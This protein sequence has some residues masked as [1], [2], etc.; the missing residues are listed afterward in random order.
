MKLNQRTLKSTPPRRLAP[1]P[2]P[3]PYKQPASVVNQLHR[4]VGSLVDATIKHDLT[5]VLILEAPC[6][7]TAAKEMLRL[8]TTVLHRR[9][10]LSFGRVA[11]TAGGDAGGLGAGPGRQR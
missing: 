4:T 2:S 9:Q 6:T 5:D 7:P 10:P 1:M 8:A 11:A 3:S